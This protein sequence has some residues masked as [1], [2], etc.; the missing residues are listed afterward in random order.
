MS[1]VPMPPSK[2]W[3]SRMGNSGW[4]TGIVITVLS[5]TCIWLALLALGQ[6]KNARPSH[7]ANPPPSQCGSNPPPNSIDDLA[8]RE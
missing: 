2:P 1:T 7:P 5:L 6:G 3:L 8:F 4:R